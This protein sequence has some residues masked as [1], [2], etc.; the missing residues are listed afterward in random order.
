MPIGY[1]LVGMDF[2]SLRWKFM[3][4]PVNLVVRGLRWLGM[5]CLIGFGFTAVEK[6]VQG[7][8]EE[9]RRKAWRESRG[10]ALRTVRYNLRDDLESI[11][12]WKLPTVD[13]EWQNGSNGARDYMRRRAGNALA[14]LN[15]MIDNNIDGNDE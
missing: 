6:L 12:D 8:V 13:Y 4:I 9:I 7:Q 14:S 2:N 3:P 15:E 10:V 1:G 11:R 5:R